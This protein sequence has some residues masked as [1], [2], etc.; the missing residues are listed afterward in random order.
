MPK[1]FVYSYALK[2]PG[3]LAAYHPEVGERLM[4]P[5]FLLICVFIQHSDEIISVLGYYVH[6]DLGQVKVWADS[7]RRP[8]TYPFVYLSHQELR[9]LL[10]IKPVAFQVCRHIKEHLVDGVNVHVLRRYVIKVDLIYGSCVLQIEFHPR[11]CHY[12]FEALRDLKYPGPAADS[13]GFQG[14]R[15]GK[16]DG[17]VRTGRIRHDKIGRH[18]IESAFH[19]LHRSIE[20]L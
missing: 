18:R 12:V 16:T 4:I 5:Q 14:R 15:H 1:F 2:L 3:S 6:C 19:A 17:A 10:R 8:D 13:A 9:H 20:R 11:R 7:R